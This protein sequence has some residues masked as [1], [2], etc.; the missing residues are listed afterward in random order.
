MP[1][2]GR[3]QGQRQDQAAAGGRGAL[4]LKAVD[5]RDQVVAILRRRLHYRSSSGKRDD[6]D[7]QI[8]RH[9]LDEVLRRRL[10]RR[11]AIGLHVLGAHAARNVHRRG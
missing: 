2:S 4:E 10:R 8:V 6:A 11:D 7:P 9:L 3:Q 5:G 1:A